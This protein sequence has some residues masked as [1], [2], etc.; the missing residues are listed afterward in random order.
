MKELVRDAQYFKKWEQQGASDHSREALFHS[1]RLDMGIGAIWPLLLKLQRIDADLSEQ[2]QWFAVLESYFVRRKIAGYQARSYDRI[3][4]ELLNAL[5]T[6]SANQSDVGETILNHLLGYT[7]TATL[8]PS[9]AA[10]KD[11]V[12]NRQHSRYAQRLVLFAIEEYL[13]TDF[14]AGPALAPS[15]QVEHLMPEGWQPESW[16][17]PDSVEPTTAAEKR[18]QA[19]QTLG[20][21]TLLNGRLNASIS[22]GPWHRKRAAIQKSDN[23]FLN[24]RLLDDSTDEWM[25]RDIYR[26]GEWM[27][28]TIVKIWPAGG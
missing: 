9:D 19:I 20:N 6:S 10:V 8:W 21:L 3:A 5:P 22:N 27:Y 12:L 18:N 13:I 28:S 25:E 4:L 16:R 24:R 15:V 26:R 17:L 14:A 7:E 23:L 1:R 2:E 11:A